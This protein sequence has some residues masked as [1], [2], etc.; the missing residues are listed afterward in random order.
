MEHRNLGRTG[1]KV[2]LLCLGTMN[3]GPQTS[4]ADSFA[5]MD[6]ALEAGINFF[7][8]ANVYGEKKGE[9][10]TEKI[11]GRWLAQG[12]GRR[13]QTVLATK[14]YGRM[15]DGP[16]ERGLS[17]F[18]IRQ[19]C[20]ESLRRLQTDH[21]DIYQMHHVERTTPW[22]EIW[23]AMEQLVQAGKVL[24]VG[25][26][27][28]AGIHIVQAQ[29]EAGLRHFMGLVSE[30]SLYNLK[31]RMIEL[32]VIPACREY[33]LGLI[34]WSPLAGGLLGGMLEKIEEGRRAEGWVQRKLKEN[35]AQVEKYEA[36]CQELGE[37]PA[38]V[39]LAWLLSNPAVTAPIIGPRTIE[40]FEGNLGALE[41]SLD[42]EALKRLDE[43]WP[44]P[45]GEA[46]EAFAW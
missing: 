26:S 28:F 14:V 23:Q 32:E 42:E 3:F 20:E 24:Y 44:G 15:G 11:I 18:H 35:H 13:E 40:Q 46:P 8:T 37:K 17:A 22:E 10:I 27:N 45:G 5:I 34:P 29:Y 31:D 33:G 43:I 38:D 1:L 6:R 25:S 36:Y 9:G 4:E 12:G 30:Q 21:I 39:A 41:I 16:N 2:S 7:D 19:A